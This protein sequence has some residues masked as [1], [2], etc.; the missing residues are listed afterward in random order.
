MLRTSMLV[1]LLLGGSMS[2]S[3]QLLPVDLS[4]L[5]P[6]PIAVAQSGA[7]L[8]FA[9]RDSTN[10]VWRAEFSLNPAQ[11]LLHEITV[12][13]RVVVHDARPVYRG[14]VGIRK[15]GWDAFFDDPSGEPDGTQRYV[16]KFAPTG[17]A[18]RS[19][20]NRIEL[21]FRGMKMGP[22]EGELRYDFYPGTSLMQ[23]VAVMKTSEPNVAYYY[24]AGLE[25]T[26][27]E[28]RTPGLNMA[29]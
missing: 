28:D 6:G 22:F 21:S 12:D 26:A 1:A 25:W 29:S 5:R 9:W 14:A 24:D 19:V 20:G 2:C 7:E 3:G 13:G 11:P 8:S 23:Q 27:D 4:A 10:Q 18:V 17:V 15:G 16:A